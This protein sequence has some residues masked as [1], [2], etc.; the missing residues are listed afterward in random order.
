MLCD[1]HMNKQQ[2]QLKKNSSYVYNMNP[3]ELIAFNITP[4][5]QKRNQLLS[6]VKKNDA[7][8]YI[9]TTPILYIFMHKH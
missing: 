3:C 5:P 2:I 8:P 4:L 1:M 6:S 9:K 7:Y